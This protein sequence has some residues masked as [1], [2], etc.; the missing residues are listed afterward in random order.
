MA[1]SLA[2]NLTTGLFFWCCN[3]DLEKVD[4]QPLSNDKS[5]HMVTFCHAP[6]TPYTDAQGSLCAKLSLMHNKQEDSHSLCLILTYKV[7]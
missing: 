3:N 4:I 7:Y 5:F 2:G 1:N 6:F